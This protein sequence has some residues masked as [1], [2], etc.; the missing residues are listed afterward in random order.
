[1]V[2]APSDGRLIG[3]APVERAEIFGGLPLAHWQSWRNPHLFNGAPLI[4]AGFENTFFSAVSA[5]LDAKPGGGRF[6]RLI[7]ARLDANAVE[8]ATAQRRI[9][10]ERTWRRAG[11]AL[12]PSHEGGEFSAA[13]IGRRFST[14]KAKELRRQRRRL[15]DVAPFRVRSIGGGASADQSP[16]DVAR[17]IAAYA[18]LEARG[19]KGARGDAVSDPAMGSFFKDA[20]HAMFAADAAM[21]VVLERIDQDPPAPIAMAIFLRHGSHLSAF[22]TAYDETYAAYSPGILVLME[23][24]KF[25]M[26]LDGVSFLDSCAKPDHPVAGK[27]WPDHCE[28]SNLLIAGGDTLTPSLIRLARVGA[29]GYHGLRAVLRGRQAKQ[30]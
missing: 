22:K 17:L 12:P 15:Q 19:W 20:M 30:R 10:T 6:L 4:A 26:T 7:E 5:W 27:L 16:D 3:L 1:L 24:T 21:A 28:V 13:D 14:K 29:Q 9:L 11:L 25:I 18:R 23:A 8:A 2:A